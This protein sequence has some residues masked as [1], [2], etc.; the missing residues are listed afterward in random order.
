VQIIVDTVSLQGLILWNPKT[1]DANDELFQYL[2]SHRY[3]YINFLFRLLHRTHATDIL[4]ISPLYFNVC[5]NVVV[6]LF[7]PSVGNVLN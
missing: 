3:Y 4:V 1:T 5:N 2:P 6:K 7:L